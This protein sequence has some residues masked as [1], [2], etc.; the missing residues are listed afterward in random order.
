MLVMVQTMH[1]KVGAH[2]DGNRF[3]C[4]KSLAHRRLSAAALRRM[5][6]QKP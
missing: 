6:A 2:T 4:R 3:G 5:Q 1:K